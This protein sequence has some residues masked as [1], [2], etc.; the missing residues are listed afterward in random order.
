MANPIADEAEGLAQLEALLKEAVAMRMV[1]DV[2]LG[3]FLSGG[4]DSSLVVALM[5]A[6]SKAPVKTF[7]IGFEE[8]DFDEAP[9]AKRV[10][11]RLGNRPHGTHGQFR[12]RHEG[13]AADSR[14]V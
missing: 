3:A 10:A 7:T 9:F 5:Q 4:T 2:P 11:N 12:G 13:I 14:S 8:K 1:A 6:Q